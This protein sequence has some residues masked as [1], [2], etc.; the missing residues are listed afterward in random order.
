MFSLLECGKKF[1]GVYA[2]NDQMA[3]GALKLLRQIGIAVP[4]Q[5][6]VI[7]TDDVF[8]ASIVSPSLSTVHIMKTR[9]GRRAAEI[10]LDR[11]TEKQPSNEVVAENM[12][13]SLVIRNSTDPLAIDHTEIA[14]W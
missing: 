1:D 13:I 14:N 3:F 11:M 9:M 2:A 5:I 10:L 7:G 6:K 4:E 8:T 12:E